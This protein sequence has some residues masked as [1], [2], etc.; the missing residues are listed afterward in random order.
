MSNISSYL[1]SRHAEQ[2]AAPYPSS[3]A[4]TAAAWAT[5]CLGGPDSKEL[6]PE[7]LAALATK[8][9]ACTLQRGQNAHTPE[10]TPEGVWIIIRGMVE[11]AFD[12]DDECIVAAVLRRGN[13][14]GD[15]PI[16]TG[17]RY[18]YTARA[19]SMTTCLFLPENSLT[20]LLDEHPAIT[21]LWVD[22]L[23]ARLSDSHAQLLGTLR[24]PMARRVAWVLLKEAREGLVDLTQST[25]AAMLGA[26]RSSLNRVLH[27][28]ATAKLVSLHYRQIRVLDIDGLADLAALT[29]EDVVTD[30]N[31]R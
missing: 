7:D 14:F 29:R 21:R 8:L 23:A 11:L 30:K 18:P 22:G 5:R 12:V 9:V 25:L 26:R 20:T 31:E 24:G 28:L 13:V 27:D 17:N 6:P 16:L 3:V 4:L 2:S 10:D 15:L 19:L 1:V